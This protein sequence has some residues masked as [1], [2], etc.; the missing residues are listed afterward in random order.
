MFFS[1]AMLVSSILLS[2]GV[3]TPSRPELGPNQDPA[4][5]LEVFLRSSVGFDVTLSPGEDLVVRSHDQVGECIMV[6]LEAL[7]KGLPIEVFLPLNQHLSDV[8]ER[9][10]DSSHGH[11]LT[12]SSNAS[13]EVLVFGSDVVEGA[14]NAFAGSMILHALDGKDYL[15]V[16]VISARPS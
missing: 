12:V 14:R 10:C 5:L 1:A 16:L 13:G 3:G 7:G 11:R 4:N 9:I 6:E 2:Y 8:L 15:A